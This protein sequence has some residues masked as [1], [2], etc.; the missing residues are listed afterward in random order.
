MVVGGEDDLNLSAVGGGS[1]EDF[2][3]VGRVH[4]CSFFSGL[5]YNPAK[6]IYTVG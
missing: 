4:S 3:G 1:L 2:L 5:V 6:Y